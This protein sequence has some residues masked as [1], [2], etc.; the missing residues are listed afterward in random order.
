MKKSKTK[1][2]PPNCPEEWAGCRSFKTFTPLDSNRSALSLAEAA[3]KFP[4]NRAANPLLLCSVIN[5]LGATHL[6]EAI[7]FAYKE[8]GMNV[9]FMSAE[10]FTTWF[11]EACADQS[12]DVFLRVLSSADALLIDDIQFLCEP[13]RPAYLNELKKV[14]ACFLAQGKQVVMTTDESGFNESAALLENLPTLHVARLCR[15]TV[16]EKMKLLAAIAESEGVVI[17]ADV[18]RYIA[19][20]C[21]N[22]RAL[23]GRYRSTVALSSLYQTAHKPDVG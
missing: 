2:M 18:N 19:S 1:S 6:M 23:I 13:D 4:G 14:L 9:I 16:E 5:G 3:A 17:P 20:L 12:V 7:A 10:R 22:I 11:Q 8:R 15:P 21:T